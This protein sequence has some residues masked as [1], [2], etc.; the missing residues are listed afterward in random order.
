MLTKEPGACPCLDHPQRAAFLIHVETCS[1]SAA[2][3]TDT[4]P[5]MVRGQEVPEPQEQATEAETRAKAA[6]G[7]L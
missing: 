5:R 1:P 2:F 6:W 4:G 3:Q 7:P